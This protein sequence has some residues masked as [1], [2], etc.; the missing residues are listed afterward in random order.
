[1]IICLETSSMI[2]SVALCDR[3]GTVALKESA[4]SRSHASQLTVF[5]DELLKE[6]GIKAAA[7][8]AIAV[9]KGPGSYTGL[10]IG[11]SVAKGIAYAA[12]IPLI[13]VDTTLAMFHGIVDIATRDKL[14]DDS[15]LFVPM[16][17]ARRMEVY[18]SVI[19]ANGEILSEVSAQV[20]DENSFRHIPSETRII[21]FGDGA[22]KCSNIIKG[23]NRIFIDNFSVSA[24]HMYKPVFKAFK[25]KR[26]EDT[27]YFEPFYLKDFITS[28]PK[29]NIVGR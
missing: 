27:A 25:E 17:D 2:C 3:D 14:A 8:D 4:D 6:A 29:K 19:T 13:A 23:P 1:M 10:R 21:F 18:F 7:L 5:I 26:F 9:S 24:S 22:P 20:I 11:V 16:I 12:S 28:R 15:T